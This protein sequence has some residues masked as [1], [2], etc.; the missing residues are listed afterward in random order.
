MAPHTRDRAELDF[1][2]R[3]LVVSA[4]AH[5]A[6][7]ARLIAAAQTPKPRAAVGT[8]DGADGASPAG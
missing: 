5:N 1:L 7:L 3:Q 8:T 2:S 4:T 6:R